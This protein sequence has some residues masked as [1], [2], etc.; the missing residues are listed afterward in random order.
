MTY[1]LDDWWQTPLGDSGMELRDLM[2]NGLSALRD[3]LKKEKRLN[4][5]NK[6]AFKQIMK[7]MDVEYAK[8]TET[9]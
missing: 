9:N 5:D 2:A 1:D 4:A 7:I 3:K 6:E 8:L